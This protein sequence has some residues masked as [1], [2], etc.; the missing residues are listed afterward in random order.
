M[1][2]RVRWTVFMS[3][4]GLAVAIVTYVATSS[5]GWAV[6][7]LFAAGILANALFGHRASRPS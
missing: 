2:Y 5:M 4:F 7:A 6:V 3:L 1:S